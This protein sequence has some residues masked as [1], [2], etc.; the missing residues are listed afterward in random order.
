MASIFI[1]VGIFFKCWFKIKKKNN[2]SVLLFSFLPFN[3]YTIWT[4][5]NWLIQS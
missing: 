2:H 3:I 5:K 1:G 4:D